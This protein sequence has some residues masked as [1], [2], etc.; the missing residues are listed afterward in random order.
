M[1]KID[2]VTLIIWIPLPRCSYQYRCSP[3]NISRK[4][5]HIFHRKKHNYLSIF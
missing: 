2:E 3:S 4:R 5:P 1:D